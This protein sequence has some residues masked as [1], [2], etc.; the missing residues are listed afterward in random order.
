MYENKEVIMAD[1]KYVEKGEPGKTCVDCKNYKDKD[2]VTGDCYGHEVLAAGSCN[3]F[4][5]K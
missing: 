4:E 5:K 1:V 3:L 2:G